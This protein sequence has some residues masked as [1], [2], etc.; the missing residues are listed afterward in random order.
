MD[1]IAEH[2]PSFPQLPE[3]A[4][5]AG[6]DEAAVMEVF[7][8]V[9]DI[10]DTLAEQGLMK[11][12]DVSLR[13]VTQ[14]P[15]DDPVAQF[16]ALGIAYLNWAIENPAQFRL[17]QHSKLVDMEGNEKLS[18]YVRAMRDTMLRLL[19]NAQ[20]KGQISQSANIHSMLLAGRCLLFGLARMIIDENMS[21]WHP[22]L[23]AADAAHQVFS[24]YMDA[25]AAAGGR[26]N[27]A[28]APASAWA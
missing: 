2:R 10:L 6:Q 24:D 15:P 14:A 13:T 16:R 18:R 8:S 25:M 23:S 1:M 7:G 28:G 5:R 26:V 9:Q 21:E 22:G 4:L 12:V 3:I 19:R 17:L 11:L 20:E 27:D